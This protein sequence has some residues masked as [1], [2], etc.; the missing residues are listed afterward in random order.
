M[1]NLFIFIK[2]NT[3]KLLIAVLGI[4]VLIILYFSTSSIFLVTENKPKQPFQNPS[5]PPVNYAS[6]T[7]PLSEAYQAYLFERTF[8]NQIA[9]LVRNHD[10]LTQLLFDR[11]YTE[12]RDDFLDLLFD[13][14]LK[15]RDEIRYLKTHLEYFEL[16]EAFHGGPGYVYLT[17]KVAVYCV[18]SDKRI[19]ELES[20]GPSKMAWAARQDLLNA[21]LMALGMPWSDAEYGVSFEEL[22]KLFL[23]A[24]NIYVR[25]EDKRLLVNW[26]AET[27]KYLLNAGEKNAADG[28]GGLTRA[29]QIEK[30]HEWL[31][32]LRKGLP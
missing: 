2:K 19:K 13:G 29:Q 26:L 27:E 31:I 21:N 17:D 9:D 18:Q 10:Q 6:K 1:R 32:R 3:R 14:L 11:L 28:Y 30:L 25:D 15:N 20:W 22:E 23:E 16:G 24:K 12:K 5:I 8:C 4:C 7:I